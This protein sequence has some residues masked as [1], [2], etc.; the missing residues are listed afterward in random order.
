MRRLREAGYDQPFTTLE[1][2]IDDYVTNHL[3]AE[4]PYR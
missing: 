4:D 1:G 3:A 2:G